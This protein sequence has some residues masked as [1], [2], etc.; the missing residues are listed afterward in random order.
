MTSKY[1]IQGRKYPSIETMMYDDMADSYDVSSV[2][3]AKSICAAADMFV[4][5][6]SENEASLKIE[7][8]YEL[9][10]GENLSSKLLG[11]RIGHDGK[12]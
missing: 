3:V 12:V 7:A 11:Q 10:T 4:F 8:I 6:Y 9:K 5:K 1:L 2:I